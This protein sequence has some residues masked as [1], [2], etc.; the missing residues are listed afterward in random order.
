MKLLRNSAFLLLGGMAFAAALPALELVFKVDEKTKLTKTF[1][2]DASFSTTD[3]RIEID[4]TE[5]EGENLPKISIDVTNKTTVTV[6]DEYVKM[7][8][9]RPALLKRS[10]DK[11]SGESKEKVNMPEGAGGGDQEQD[12]KRE[13]KL[14]GQTVLFT[15][16]AKAE[17]YNATYDESSKDGDADLL[18]DLREDMDLRGFLPEKAVSEGDS[19]ELTGRVIFENVGIPGGDM[20]IDSEDDD[21]EERP[22]MSTQMLENCEGRWPQARRHQDHR[23]RQVQRQRADEEPRRRTADGAQPQDRGR[24]RVR[25]RAPVGPQGGALRELRVAQPGEDDPAHVERGRDARRKLPHRRSGFRVRRRSQVQ[26]VGGVSPESKR[27]QTSSSTCASCGSQR[28]QAP[29]GQS[30]SV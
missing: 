1:I 23:S 20:H 2:D 14:E 27:P 21:P 16:D 12:T 3:F 19:W 18:L 15:W 25:G 6:T 26:R 30:L 8:E 7:A 17:E 28:S 29:I 13:S 5:I 11:L 4:G 10:F 9:G 22:T 24:L